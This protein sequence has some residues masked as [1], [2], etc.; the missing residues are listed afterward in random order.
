MSSK[1]RPLL[2]MVT[3][4]VCAAT[5]PALAQ[6]LV[7][8]GDFE[9]PSADGQALPPHWTQ[10][11]RDF[12]PLL[13]SPR[14]F[15]GERAGMMLGDG[16]ARMWRQ[17]VAA[18]ASRSWLLSA[19]VRR[20]NVV[21][22]DGADYCRLYAHVFYKD[23]PASAATHFWIDVP[24]GSDDWNRLAIH[25]AALSDA[26]IDY[27]AVS[28]LGKFSDGRV[29][30]DDVSLTADMSLS[31]TA[32]LR[33]KVDDL[34]TNLDR[35]GAVD[36]SVVVSRAS[37]D[38]AV[39]L[40]E[41]AEPDVAKATR[42]WHAAARAVSHDAW[43]AMFPDAMSDAPVEAQ[44][45]YHG[46]GRT[47]AETDAYLDKIELAG[48]NG[49]YL[50]FGSWMHVTYHSDLLPTSPGWEDFDAL[51]YFIEQAHARGIKVFGYFAPFYGT[52]SPQVMPGSIYA[53]H[54]EW[55]ARGPDAN[56][57]TFPDPASPHVLAFMLEVYRELAT[58]YDLDGIGLDYIRYPTPASLNFDDHNL[59][60]LRE[61]FGVDVA[62]KADWPRDPQIA[63]KVRQYRSEN[64]G[65]IIEQVTRTVR[66]A[67]PGTAIMACL[68]S[69]PDVARDG[70]GQNWAES[71]KWIDYASPMNYDDH[72]IDAALLDEQRAACDRT[73][74]VW[75]PAIGG[76]PEVHRQWTLST[77]AHRVAVQR[78]HRADGIII[79]RIGDL[80]EA[81]AAFFG[82]GPFYHDATFPPAVR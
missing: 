6:N 45:L 25:G 18:P 3:W 13:A 68:I 44:M 38:R 55:F 64:V 40:L 22:A 4:M 66:D 50:S 71:S 17:H 54:P 59:A 49:V 36:D 62:G 1:T 14:K 9:S 28:V 80:D 61:R 65:R 15:S 48:C 43:A 58:R 76:M 79:Y 10:T 47:A 41:Q 29:Y 74:A 82:N 60:Q 69:E 37:L 31:D 32:L 26:P 35:I 56:M 52:S 11:H 30:V 39:E 2:L 33:G 73:G 16:E 8:N 81:V 57:P 7:L 70:Y 72:S 34:R 46:M 27:I 12:G 78:R 21:Y 19:M 75:I 20:E 63:G 53:E 51:T 77:W 24:A 67:S 23:K 5:L 42:A